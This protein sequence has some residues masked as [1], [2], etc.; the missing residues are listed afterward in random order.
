MAPLVV[1]AEPVPAKA[2]PTPMNRFTLVR[3]RVRRSIARTPLSPRFAVDRWLLATTKPPLAM[4]Y[5]PRFNRIR[6]LTRSETPPVRPSSG[7]ASPAITGAQAIAVAATAES[8]CPEAPL[9]C[10]D[11][12]L[13]STV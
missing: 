2:P 7:P 1:I 10:T 4:T 6:P 3:S 9:Y 13:T 5:P 11:R 12:S 8:D